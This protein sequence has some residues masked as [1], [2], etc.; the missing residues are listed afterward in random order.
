LVGD[1]VG[2]TRQILQIC[3]HDSAPFDTICARFVEAATAVDANVR[4]VFLARAHAQPLA[5]AEYLDAPDL[6]ATRQLRRAL[7]GWSEQPWELVLCH[8]YRAY[9]SVVGTALARNPCVVLAHEFGLMQR[10]QRRLNRRLYGRGFRFAGVSP[11]LAED[12][13]PAVGEALVI[14]NVVDVDAA[15]RLLLDRQAAR[16]ALGIAEDALVIGVVGR[17]HPR[18]RPAMA[19]QAFKIFRSQHPQA[20]LVFLG[21]G[22]RGELAEFA[23]ADDVVI[24][25]F[26]AQASAHMRAF[27]ILLHTASAEAFGM[28]VLEAMLA[29][30][31]V[32]TLPHKG[33]QFV[34]GELGVYPREDTPA[35]FAA[36]LEQALTL[37]MQDYHS[38]ALGRVREHF[39]VP[40]LAQA[41]RGLL[42][43]GAKH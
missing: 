31:P 23:S 39:S 10:W 38:Q 1:K 8:R 25:G 5:F 19:A 3:P 33:P 20:Q 43:A 16:A 36:A 2:V 29:G 11:A 7:R 34:L 40:A 24:K 21:D 6:T 17:L 12:L 15:T 37:D 9:W 18:K 28:V 22:D 26:V 35:A 30:L 13:R 4:T 41:L 27:D 32:V 14:P 42:D